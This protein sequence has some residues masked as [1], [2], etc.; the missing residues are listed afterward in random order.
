MRMNFKSFHFDHFLFYFFPKFKIFISIQK[1][2]VQPAE[3]RDLRGG[4]AAPLLHPHPHPPD[5][6]AR[7]HRLPLL[8]HRGRRPQDAGSALLQVFKL[9]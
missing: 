8:H 6:A 4:G 9:I 1:I 2:V 3:R 5:E 7:Q